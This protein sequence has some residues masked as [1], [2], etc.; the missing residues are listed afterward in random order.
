MVSAGLTLS[1][2]PAHLVFTIFGAGHISSTT[3]C[4]A[5]GKEL[6]PTALFE[7]LMATH[8]AARLWRVFLLV[9]LTLVG[10]KLIR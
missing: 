10:I 5:D 7:L 6:V 4:Q 2:R 1:H 9:L 8:D 3:I